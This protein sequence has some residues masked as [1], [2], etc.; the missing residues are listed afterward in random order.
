[1]KNI[2][3]NIKYMTS[4]WIKID[5]KSLLY[6]FLRIPLMVILPLISAYI[7]KSI[8]EYIQENKSEKEILLNISFLCILLVVTSWLTPFL[9]ELLNGTSRIIRIYYSI[10]AFNKNMEI[11]Y[12]E[13]EKLEVREKSKLAQNFYYKNN[14]SSTEFIEII[15][16]CCVC[17]IGI[18]S[19]SIIIAKHNIIILFLILCS[20]ITEFILLHF[21]K[22]REK[23]TI[24]KRSKIYLK[25]D[26]FF[27]LSKDYSSSKDKNFWI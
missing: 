21:I 2:Y 27:N 7:P 1:M 20:S 25:L 24:N 16:Q 9:K 22:K 6:F 13:L 10:M 17:I 15:N 23:D 11:D 26:Y 4:Y 19:S 18:I 12:E 5:K 14:S 3:E 8:I